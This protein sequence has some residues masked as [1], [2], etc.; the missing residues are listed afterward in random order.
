MTAD[1]RINL[2]KS[3][4][5]ACYGIKKEKKV[6]DK[7]LQRCIIIHVDAGMAELVDALVSGTSGETRA[8]S[9][10]VTR[11]ISNHGKP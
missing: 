3:A 8:G 6:L 5:S 10:P 2:R 9:S 7:N 4:V 1:Y 11:T